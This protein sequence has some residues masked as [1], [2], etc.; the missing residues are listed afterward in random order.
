M[1]GPDVGP[2]VTGVEGEELGDFEGCRDGD[3]VGCVYK[4]DTD[5]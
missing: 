5:G 2:E 4:E 3:N 1:L